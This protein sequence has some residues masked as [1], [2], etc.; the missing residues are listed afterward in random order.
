M[1]DFDD[2]PKTSPETPVALRVR[3][4]QSGTFELDPDALRKVADALYAAQIRVLQERCNAL[5]L[6]LATLRAEIT[7]ERRPRLA[8]AALEQVDATTT[9]PRREP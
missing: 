2:D 4:R 5:E 3:P 1:S 7:A 8:R 6:D 9:D